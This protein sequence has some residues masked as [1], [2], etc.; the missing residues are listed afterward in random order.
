MLIAFTWSFSTRWSYFF[1]T[2]RDNSHDNFTAVTKHAR[3][4]ADAKEL[5]KYEAIE[6]RDANDVELRWRMERTG[7]RSALFII[8]LYPERYK[9]IL[10]QLVV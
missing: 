4:A 5:G 2:I 10:N 3:A 8:T 7:G 1:F 9:P 6:N